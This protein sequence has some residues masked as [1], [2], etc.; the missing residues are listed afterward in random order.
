MSSP[1]CCSSGSASRWPTST[2]P[3]GVGDFLDGQE[4]CHVCS[5]VD[6]VAPI[7]LAELTG[8]ANIKHLVAL[9]AAFPATLVNRII[10]KGTPLFPSDDAEDVD[11]APADPWGAGLNMGAF[12][13]QMVWGFVD[14][15]EDL[16]AGD[17][18]QSI[19]D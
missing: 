8:P 12:G 2:R 10:N 1:P 14:F 19:P 18:A 11:G 17:N 13:V 7:L 5:D 6:N 9:L 16:K 3:G 15:Y 4:G